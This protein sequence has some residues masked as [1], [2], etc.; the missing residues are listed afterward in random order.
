MFLANVVYDN[1]LLVVGNLVDDKLGLAVAPAE[2]LVCGD[3]LILDLDTAGR[4]SVN[5][6]GN[7]GKPN[8]GNARADDSPRCELC[9]TKVSI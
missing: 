6:G 3:T 2:I 7:E 5:N 8:I 9:D 1:L 4:E